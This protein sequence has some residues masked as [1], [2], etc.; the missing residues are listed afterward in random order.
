MS[1]DLH[2]LAAAY[3]LDA[4]DPA[5]RAEFEA[6]LETCASCRTDVDELREAA[7]ELGAIAASPPPPHLRARVLDEIARTPQLAGS[8][9]TDELAE[10]RRRRVPALLASAAALVILV[11]G[12]AFVIRAGGGSNGVDSV[13]AAAD[14]VEVT[15][16][17]VSDDAVGS[18]RVVWS[19][20]E[21]RVAVI[22][23]DL[24]DPG[25]DR[26]Y[27]LWAIVDATPVPAGLFEVD[28]GALSD[29]EDLDVEPIAWGVTV[30]PAAGSEEPTTPILF[31]GEI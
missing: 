5:E 12:A 25:A 8:A 19:S 16:A 17:P 27:E 9:P 21:G 23:S 6:H 22:G 15:L 14:A 29:V 24:P 18:V 1:G 11:V 26:V 7:G 10:R 28:G 13:L 30:E 3:A 2:A 20:A 31:Y 4:L